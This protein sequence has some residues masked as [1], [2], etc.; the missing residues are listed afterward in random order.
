MTTI[1][2]VD[3]P[4]S[5]D[6]Q[7]SP[8]SEIEPKR[9]A[10]LD[11]AT[12]KIL[13]IG[14]GTFGLSTAYH[15]QEDGFRDV[16]VLDRAVELPA[17]D[18]ASTDINKIVRST[19]ADRFYTRLGQEAIAMWKDPMWEGCYHE[20]GVITL[21]DAYMQH[22]YE[23]DVA[24]CSRVLVLP[25]PDSIRSAFPKSDAAPPSRCDALGTFTAR[26]GYMNYDG[27]W[28]EAA[29]AIKILI[30]VV[31]S[32]G[33]KVEGGK[34][35]VT[36]LT[37]DARA[38]GS[39][40]THGVQCSDGSTYFADRVIV[41]TGSWTASNFPGL[42]LDRMCLAT[43]QTLGMIQLSA[44]EAKRYRECPVVLDFST[45]HYVLPPNANNIIKTAVNSAGHTH[46]VVSTPRTILSHPDDSDGL[47]V[48]RSAL[49]ILRDRLRAVYP[50]LAEKP[51]A[52][53]RLCWYTDSPDSDW[54]IGEFPG[55]SGLFLATSGSGHAFKATHSN[56]DLQFLPN[57]GR[58]VSDI[59]QGKADAA[60]VAKCSINR[61]AT[62]AT[63]AERVQ[64]VAQELDL[65]DL[66]GVEDLQ[67]DA[68]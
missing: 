45:G 66:C 58:V 54:V 48:P 38:D 35:V 61:V 56:Q 52:D 44:E 16:V 55:D 68:V 51:W 18:A 37:E 24:E 19:Y 62:N 22:S 14:A 11:P 6:T 7:S 60:V 9:P 10:P 29:R 50:E 26:T 31:V 23:N 65:E 25:D 4:P 20:S 64:H 17:R 8:L 59:L 67:L 39:R 43:G 42:E 1:P 57:V 28:A 12:S 30:D 63:K 47:R 5:A 15:L 34:E 41:A 27:G 36:L 33:A 32:R 53:T 21:G 13:I 3:V 49:R 2:S 40:R 46:M